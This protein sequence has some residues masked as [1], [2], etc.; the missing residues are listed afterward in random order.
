MFP[1]LADLDKSVPLT[2][3]Y[4]KDSWV[5]NMTQEDFEEMRKGGY[6]DVHVILNQNFVF[7]K[8]SHYSV[9]HFSL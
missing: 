8:S 3:I 9:F 6:I 7:V 5:Q 2:V 1:R 4:G